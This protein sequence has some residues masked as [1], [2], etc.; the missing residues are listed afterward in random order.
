MINAEKLTFGF[1][2]TP[3]FENI[4]FSLEENC[5]CALIG[6][7]G[8]GKTTLM[9]LIR[10][11]GRFLYDGKLRMEGAVRMG[12]VSQFAIREGDQS[13]TVYDYLCQDFLDL[14]QQIGQVCL[15]METAEDLDALM[16][17]YQQLLDESD[18]VDADNHEVNI[19]K[20]RSVVLHICKE[21]RTR[22]RIR[23]TCSPVGHLHG[24]G[25]KQED[26]TCERGVEG[27]AAQATEGHLTDAYSYESAHKHNPPWNTH[28]EVEGQ[29]HAGNDSRQVT[30]GRATLKQEAANEVLEHHA[31]CNSH[32]SK[33]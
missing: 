14:E 25:D 27:V 16:E 6:S 7:N 21:C 19:R 33:E 5:H 11:P 15:E 3:L 31:A 12:Y 20:Q 1:S 9:D 13:V 10:E 22:Q 30:N 23:Y 18:A 2:S 26:T 4:S 32:A 8:T 17:R 28:G 29:Q 24:V